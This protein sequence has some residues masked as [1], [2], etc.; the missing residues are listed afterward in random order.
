MRLVLD[1]RTAS[2]AALIDYAGLL[3]PASLA[4]DEAV[5]EYRAA[6]ASRDGW[7]AGR[8][9]CQASRLEE[10][11]GVLTR[12]LADGEE[13]WEIGAIFDTE[14]GS[15]AAIAQSFH[16]EMQPAAIIAQGDVRIGNPTGDAI[17]ALVDSMVSVQ[18]EIVPFLEV[19]QDLSVAEQVTTTAEVLRKR[20]RVGGVELRCGGGTAN[21][22]PASSDVA[23]FVIEATDNGMPFKMTAGLDEPMRHF[24]RE[25]NAWRHGFVNILVAAAAAANGRSPKTVNCII[26]ETDPSAF[27]I[28]AAFVSWRNLSIPGPIMRRIRTQGFVAYSS[29][30]FFEP[31]EALMNLS[32]LGEGT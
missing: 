9:L 29:C 13:P 8:F 27:S 15:A 24:D 16:A 3:A 10:L 23:A 12:S 21:T 22:F 30:G 32:F 19:D 4:M 7:V 31:V 25:L 26:E 18:P 17:G 6:R 28:R 1:A 11:A 20:G 14:P 2:F 5:S